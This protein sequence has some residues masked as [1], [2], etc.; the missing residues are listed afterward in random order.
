MKKFLILGLVALGFSS[1]SKETIDSAG[2]DVAQNVIRT[3]E[4]KNVV[5]TVNVARK[6]VLRDTIAAQSKGT[7]L[8]FDK[9]GFA[10]VYD[11][12][13]GSK[14]FAYDMPTNK[15]MNFDKVSYMIKENIIQ[16]TVKFTL[17]N[18]SET[19]TTTIEFK[20]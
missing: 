12:K 9:D 5:K 15:S 10:Y 14:S 13:G 3:G 17:Q 4:W 8:D 19:T 11:G 6:E 7:Y 2:R 18:S 20:R 1:C 16:S